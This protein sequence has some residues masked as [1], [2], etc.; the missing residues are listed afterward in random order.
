MTPETREMLKAASV[1]LYQLTPTERVMVRARL[2]TEAAR[3]MGV[4]HREEMALGPNDP[5]EDEAAYLAEFD[6]A[7]VAYIAAEAVLIVF[8]HIETGTPT[9]GEGS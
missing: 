1:W 8:A 9:E 2:R 5:T 4:R 3:C 7:S 6:A